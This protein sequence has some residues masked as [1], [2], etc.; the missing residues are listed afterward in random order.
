MRQV[1]LMNDVFSIQ[2]LKDG[3]ASETIR[4]MSGGQL[5]DVLDNLSYQPSGILSYSCW[6]GVASSSSILDFTVISLPAGSI[7]SAVFTRSL[8][9]SPAVIF[10]RENISRGDCRLICVISKN[11][12]LFTPNAADDLRELAEF[13]SKEFSVPTSSIYISCTGIIGRRLPMDSIKSAICGASMKLASEN[14]DAS[15]TAIMTTDSGPKVGSIEY[16]GIRICGMV[17]G[18]GMIEPNM[19]TMLAYF[20]TNARISKSMLD[21][22]TKRVCGQTF[23]CISIDTD[24]STSDS[25]FVASTNEH[26][27]SEL[28]IPA[29]ET[30]LLALSCKLTREL[31]RKA[32][33]ATKLI[34]VTVE[35]DT[36]AQDARRIAKSIVNSPLVKTAVHGS[37]PNWGR[38]VMAI[39]KCFDQVDRK[40]VALNELTIRVAGVKVFDR[41]LLD[42]STE[43]AALSKTLQ[44][45]S[46]VLIEVLIGKPIYGARVWGCDLS[47]EYVRLNALYTT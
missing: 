21:E 37:D 2:C 17:K 15:A 19:A 7:V 14:L 42:A 16:R 6:A 13:L 32:E 9:A 20:F 24:T 18:A 46:E 43:L 4:A 41:G 10:D 36:S 5:I 26:V 3:K 29:F 40:I 44:Q 25:V 39:G 38:I 12:N 33:G 22:I 1:L 35:I 28:E 31:V 8:C 23:N 45:E 30:A 47:E 27:V 11:A 34:E